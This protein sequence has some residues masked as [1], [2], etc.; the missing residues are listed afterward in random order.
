MYIQMQIYINN[1]QKIYMAPARGHGYTAKWGYQTIT[2]LCNSTHGIFYTNE[3]KS[4]NMQNMRGV[5]KNPKCKTWE[6]SNKTPNVKFERV[7]CPLGVETHWAHW[8]LGPP[9]GGGWVPTPPSASAWAQHSF[10]FYIFGFFEPSHLLHFFVF[11][12]FRPCTFSST[13]TYRW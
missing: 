1:K 3:L 6:G 4:K 11:D 8:A 5:P 12:S 9:G 7:L 13:F 10:S 2:Y